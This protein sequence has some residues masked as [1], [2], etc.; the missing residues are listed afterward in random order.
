MENKSC[1]EGDTVTFRCKVADNN[2][3]A[4]WLKDWKELEQRSC[5]KEL[6]KQFDETNIHIQTFDI[7]R[8]YKYTMSVDGRYHT[9]TINNTELCDAGEYMIIA[10]NDKMTATLK[11][12]GIFDRFFSFD[13]H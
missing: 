8:L 11:I 3:S 10:N 12:K 4:K 1:I 7:Q 9:L 13:L 5:N 2:K 6:D